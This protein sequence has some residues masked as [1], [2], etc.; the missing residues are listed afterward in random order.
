MTSDTSNKV[1]IL[2]V[3]VFLIVMLGP[4]FGFHPLGK[5]ELQPEKQINKTPVENNDEFNVDEVMQDDEQEAPEVIDQPE[6]DEEVD[7]P[8][9]EVPQK[10]RDGFEER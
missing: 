5:P 6:V 7:E 4:Y 9:A 1:L 2:L 10:R 8:A 3:L